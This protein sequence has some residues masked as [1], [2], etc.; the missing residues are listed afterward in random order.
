[1]KVK[2]CGVT[3]A[4]DAKLACRLGAWA[5]GLVFAAHSPRR[6]TIGEARLA[7]RAIAPGVLAVGVFEGNPDEEVVRI[8]ESV[9]LGA[10]QIRGRAPEALPVPVFHVLAPGETPPAGADSVLVEPPR[11]PQDRLAGKKPSAEEQR[12]AW[13]AASELRVPLVIVAGGLTPENVAE[14]ARLSRCGAVD[15]SSGIE[16]APGKKDPER[17]ERFFAALKGL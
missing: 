10:A 1:M 6:L 12:L 9:G 5:V 17:L 8:V 16:T 13:R 2:V 7:R 14:A 11:A 3:S 15:V 4:E